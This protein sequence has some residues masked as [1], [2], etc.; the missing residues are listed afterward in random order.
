MIET[1]TTLPDFVTI[2][3]TYEKLEK[4]VGKDLDW[5]KMQK[6]YSAKGRTDDT[7]TLTI[8]EYNSIHI[9]EEEERL[10]GYTIHSCGFEQ[11]GIDYFTDY[12]QIQLINP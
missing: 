10:E 2:G 4:I 7:L 12:T 3:K 8:Y 6:L 11:W 5:S 1:C 9:L